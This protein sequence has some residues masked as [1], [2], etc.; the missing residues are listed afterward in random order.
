MVTG[1]AGRINYIFSKVFKYPEKSNKF[2]YLKP[3][4]YLVNH[5]IKIFLKHVQHLYQHLGLSIKIFT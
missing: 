4:N 3:K 5:A 1:T 2:L